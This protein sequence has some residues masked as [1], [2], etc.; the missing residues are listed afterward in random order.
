QQLCT[1]ATII[2]SRPDSGGTETSQVHTREGYFVFLSIL[3]GTVAAVFFWSTDLSSSHAKGHIP[4]HL[5]LLA[6]PKWARHVRLT[7][8]GTVHPPRALTM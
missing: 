6:E 4:S 3:A 1:G 8:L 7:S 5:P 2:D